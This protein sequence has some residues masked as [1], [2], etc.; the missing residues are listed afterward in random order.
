M[1][2]NLIWKLEIVLILYFLWKTPVLFF[3]Y[4][5]FPHRGFAIYKFF[6]ETGGCLVIY[7]LVLWS[8]LSAG[9]RWSVWDSAWVGSGHDSFTWELLL[10]FRPKASSEDSDDQFQWRRPDPTFLAQFPPL[11][12]DSIVNDTIFVSTFVWV[13]QVSTF[14][15]DCISIRF[16][17]EGGKCKDPLY[18]SEPL[19]YLH[20]LSSR[21]ACVPSRACI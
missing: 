6:N 10:S 9:Q 19:H 20:V 13:W 1:I 11:L 4:M 8:L 12:N 21:L 7:H 16:P 3:L 18:L 15:F 17:L 14:N 2:F 5:D